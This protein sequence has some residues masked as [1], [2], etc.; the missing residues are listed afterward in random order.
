MTRLLGPISIWNWVFYGA[1]VIRGILLTTALLLM[2][3]VSARAD[4]VGHGAPVRDVE[5]SPDGR[6]AATAGFD[7]ITILWSLAD[8]SQLARFYG[9]EAGVNAVTFLPPLPGA[10][11]PRVISVS[12][13]GTA[14]IWDGDTGTILHILQGH[15]KKVVAVA[16]SPD[17]RQVATASWDR[18]VRLWDATSG[19][20][21]RIFTGHTN[22][23]NDVVFTPKGESLISAGYDG[24][25]R[26]WPLAE[27][28]ESYRFAKVG[29][30]INGLALSGDGTVLVSGSSD[31]TVRVWDVES[32]T[33]K[34]ELGNQHDGAVLAVAISLDGKMIASGGV[35]GSLYL[36]NIG[37]QVPRISLQVEHY[38]AVWSLAFTPDG[39]RIYAGGIDSVVRGWLTVTGD[40]V[41]GQSTRFQPVE[42]V[43][44][45]MAFS[46]DPVERGSYQF[47]KCAICH[48]LKPG[49]PDRSGPS[50]AGIFGR[51]AG[52]LPGYTYSE[53][54]KNTPVVWD[55]ETIAHLFEIG[56]NQMFPGTK[57][58]EQRL[59]NSQ[60]RQDLVE[61]LKQATRDISTK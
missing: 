15:E 20:L 59:T 37:S 34:Q 33:L 41:I 3:A 26:V 29:F 32:G 6:Y 54:L 40:S 14:R 2:M 55:E 39:S 45:S 50:L 38:R 17:G 46:D 43:P 30:P 18:T 25:I 1:V 4:F 51:P 48:A 21:L 9:H 22:S 49:G 47:R 27:G 44:S 61:F 24:D 36:W 5:I 23:V 10:A 35:G 11:R 52:T 16:A 58:P 28:A 42:R 13:D 7:D 31:Q 53:A 12:D 57:M 56:P 19:Q 60:D 8:R